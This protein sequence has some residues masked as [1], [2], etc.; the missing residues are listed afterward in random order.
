MKIKREESMQCYSE[1]LIATVK[2]EFVGVIKDQ[3]LK[4]AFNIEVR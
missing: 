3:R 4:A 2:R 1:L